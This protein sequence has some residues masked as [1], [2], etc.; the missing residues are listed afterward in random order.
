MMEEHQ[1]N[2]EELQAL[3]LLGLEITPHS[4]PANGWGYIWQERQWTGP[5]PTP[6]AAI[7]A[8]FTE[9]R[10]ALQFRNKY[11]WV[12]SAHPGEHRQFTGESWMQMDGSQK[13]ERRDIET[14]DV[15]A[16]ARQDWSN[17]E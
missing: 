9:A 5:F 6:D 14:A 17:D 11:A 2:P 16:Q 8:A 3:A 13:R 10:H 15:E 12:V 1:W 7:H 4:D